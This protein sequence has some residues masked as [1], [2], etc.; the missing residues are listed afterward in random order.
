MA[1]LTSGLKLGTASTSSLIK[2]ANS[3]ATAE[4]NLQ[5]KAMADAY[6]ASAKTADDYATYVDYLNG[7]I[8]A[9]QSVGSIASESKI[10]TYQSALRSALS[11]N[12]SADI[13]RENIAIMGGSS[14]DTQKLS[15]VGDEFQR[16][17]ANG[18]MAL[19]QSL[20][21]TYYSLSQKI[22]YD[23]QQAQAASTALSKAAVGK[24][25]DTVTGLHNDLKN[26]VADA[27]NAGSEAELNN[28]L[29]AY[30]KANAPTFNAL[31][32]KF[33]TNQ[34]N[35]WDV[36]T[37]VIGSIYTHRVLQAV[38]EAPVDPN[39]A[40]N[41]LNDAMQIMN[42]SAKFDTPAGH[43]MTFQEV[44]QASQDPA[45]FSY[46]S[47]TN[48]YDQTAQ[49]GY[50]YQTFTGYKTNAQGQVSSYNYQALVPQF[51][52]IVGDANRN[53]VFFL[54][55]NQTTA[56]TQLG[57]NFS[58]NSKGTSGDGVFFQTTSNT[59]LW[60]KQ[61]LGGPQ[62]TAD[63]NISAQAFTDN[64]GNLI[65][66]GSSPTG[67]GPAFMTI[68]KDTSGKF[69]VFVHNADGTTSHGLSDYGFNWGASSLL[70]NAGAQLQKQIQIN[71]DAMRQKINL[72]PAPK[73]P[74]IVTTP[75]PTPKV[76]LS[77]SGA[78]SNAVGPKP[79]NPQQAGNVQAPA[80]NVQTGGGSVQGGN[81]DL[82]ASGGGGIKL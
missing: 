1:S 67:E 64:E 75:V 27:K 32:V 37:G 18:D 29:A 43:Q 72:P 52:G 49:I 4:Q 80:V 39:A 24:E 62:S 63:K 8:A 9:E 46:N 23:A 20:E 51:S 74:S 5:D 2:S 13:T 19:A 44:Q 14:T 25:E 54:T 60:L 45:M 42:G 28:T 68:M 36:L 53:K 70:V 79:T 30:A 15:L 71:T 33:N 17:W 50:Q 55:A 11:T 10:L 21:S 12:T 73:L 3:L 78:P 66:K 6:S 77:S 56:M 81:F 7:R 48:T 31:G 82:Q 65:V 41:Y 59:P 61:M 40:G 38:A 26:F 16:A 58:E 57:L 22:Q 47:A 69:G 34:P 76:N 35:I